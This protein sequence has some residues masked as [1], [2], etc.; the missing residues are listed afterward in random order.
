MRSEVGR[1]SEAYAGAVVARIP[2]GNLE[3]VTKDNLK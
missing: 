3:S 1:T 2:Q